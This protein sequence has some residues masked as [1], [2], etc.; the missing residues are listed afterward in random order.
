MNYRKTIAT[1]LSSILVAAVLSSQAMGHAAAKKSNPADG[2]E[3]TES[4]IEITVQFNGP[5]KLI[6]MKVAGADGEALE[7]DVSNAKSVDGL[8]SV[9]IPALK[10]DSYTVMWRVMSVDGH[11]SAGKFT[12]KVLASDGS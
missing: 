12:F 6:T 9:K 7:I 3:L 2:A 1:I 4:P 11:P 5:A 8:V 10:P